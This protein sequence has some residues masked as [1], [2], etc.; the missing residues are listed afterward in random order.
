MRRQN[1]LKTG[2]LA[3]AALL[4]AGAARAQIG[5]TDAP[6][7]MG[8]E[9]DVLCFGYVGPFNEEFV[10]SLISG[11]AVYE[12]SSFGFQD[13]V[14]AENLGGIRAGDEYWF[15]T[16]QDE[17]FDST[18]GRSLGQFYEYRGYAKALCVKG[19][20]AIL[21]VLFACTDIPIGARLKPYEA[22]PV[23]LARRS[24]LVSECEDPSGKVSGALI[25]SRDGV[26]SL[27]TGNDAIVNIGASAGISPGDFLTIY[28]YASPREFDI[29]ANGRLVSYRAN[30]VP[31]RTILGEAAVLT[32][33][34]QS[35]TVHVIYAT[36]AIALGDLVEL[37]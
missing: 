19:Q 23:P 13:I 35:A 31:P 28:R 7:P 10:G 34:D 1:F 2:C 12:Q 27:T 15:I 30:L 32:V 3:V 37:K 33:G 20:A 14:Y 18:S 8:S 22:I 17:V 25:Y 5:S 4:L 11:D 6:Q 29:D 24:E 21:E 36:H 26:E 9:N 16:P